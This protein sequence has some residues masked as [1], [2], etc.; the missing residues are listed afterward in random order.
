MKI[1]LVAGALCL[2]TALPAHAK[3]GTGQLNGSWVVLVENL[4]V[5]TA[6]ITNGSI[7]IVGIGTLPISQSSSCRVVMTE[8]SG[9]LVGSSESIAKSSSLKPRQIDVASAVSGVTM[10]LVRQ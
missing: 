8:A 2:A 9:N 7:S 6:T 3:C 10:S 4:G 1:I 5:T